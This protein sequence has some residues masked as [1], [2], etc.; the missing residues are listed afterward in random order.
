MT[1]TASV[2]AFAFLGARPLP[3]LKEESHLFLRLSWLGRYTTAAS[4]LCVSTFLG[5]LAGIRVGEPD[6]Q[7]IVDGVSGLIGTVASF[8][9]QIAALLFFGVLMID[10]WR[11][12]ESR[13]LEG[14]E[15]SL[16]KLRGPGL[17]TTPLN[18]VVLRWLA[19]LSSPLLVCVS[20]GAIVVSLLIALNASW[21]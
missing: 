20:L 17:E 19:A 15:R 13:R 2:T 16:R 18:A 7:S 11:M 21:R 6:A 14:I 9:A 12:G 3:A 1:L 4:V 8:A 10:I 5:A